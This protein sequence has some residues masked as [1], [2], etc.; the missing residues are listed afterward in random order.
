[1]SRTLLH[2][3]EELK[4]LIKHRP[5]PDDAHRLLRVAIIGAPNAGKSTLLNKLINWKVVLL[6]LLFTSDEEL[7]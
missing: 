6:L 5:L 1:M 3:V 7:L 4:R 2:G